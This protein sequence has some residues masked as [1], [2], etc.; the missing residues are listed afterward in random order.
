MNQ[1]SSNVWTAKRL[2]LQNRRKLLSSMR[3]SPVTHAKDVVECKIRKAENRCRTGAACGA[4]PLLVLC[5]TTLRTRRIFSLR[6][7]T[8]L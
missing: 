7:V 3:L 2:L 4:Y 5:H 8:S 1:G 6:N